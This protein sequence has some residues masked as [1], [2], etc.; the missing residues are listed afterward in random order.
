MDLFFQC[1]SAL[2]E[3]ADIHKDNLLD[4]IIRIFIYPFYFE[5]DDRYELCKMGAIFPFVIYFIAFRFKHLRPQFLIFTILY[6]TFIVIS[7]V[8]VFFAS[9]FYYVQHSINFRDSMLCTFLPVPIYLYF[10]A[11]LVYYKYSQHKTQ[12][13]GSN[14]NDDNGY[15]DKKCSGFFNFLTFVQK[16]LQNIMSWVNSL[17]QKESFGDFS[18]N[19]EQSN[20]KKAI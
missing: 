16:K 3:A 15:S 7:F 4:D 12:K 19:D 13:S 18:P 17:D 5:S 10:I 9:Y 1:F 2:Y 20:N 6:I 11:L 14:N 8:N